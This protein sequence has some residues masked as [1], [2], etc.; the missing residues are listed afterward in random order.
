MAADPIVIQA[1]APTPIVIHAP[2]APVVAPSLAVGALRVPRRAT[3]QAIH[4]K[5]GVPV[6]FRAPA[7]ASVARLRLISRAGRVIATKLVALPHDGA[8]LVHLRAKTARRG[9]YN[10]EVATGTSATRLGPRARAAL[11]VR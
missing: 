10:V 3:L 11:E 8:Q 9:R 4:S 2:A 7:G 1:P 6:R 5:S